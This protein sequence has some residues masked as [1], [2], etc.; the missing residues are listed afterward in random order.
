MAGRPDDSTPPA[1]SAVSR[2]GGERALCARAMRSRRRRRGPSALLAAS[3]AL[4]AVVAASPVAPARASGNVE[5][6]APV[7]TRATSAV[8]DG[9]GILMTNAPYG[10]YTGR[11]FASDEVYELFLTHS[12]IYT[13]DLIVEPRPGGEI[14]QCGWVESVVLMRG[15]AGT[16]PPSRCAGDPRQTFTR[17]S[18]GKWFNCAPQA[19]VDGAATH[20][21][22]ACDDR[23]YYN[24]VA[25]AYRSGVP[26]SVRA[27]GTY[28]Y[29]GRLSAHER[30]FY[31]YTSLDG[32]A[33][34]VRSKRF[35]WIFVSARCIAGHPTGGTAKVPS[36]ALQDEKLATKIAVAARSIAAF[37]QRSLA[38]VQAAHAAAAS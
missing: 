16:A 26:S 13:Y 36:F 22:D 5:R 20:L 28:D 27:D 29:A 2:A 6:I 15:R 12:R 38:A 37:L 30:V 4:S 9:K 34:I 25:R 11:L 3:L 1:P 24:Q 8:Q 19:C 23:A 33:A 35:G 14:L 18:F 21:T 31:R 10:Y 7:Q 32:E 17:P